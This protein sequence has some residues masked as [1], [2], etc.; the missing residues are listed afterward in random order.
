MTYKLCPLQKRSTVGICGASSFGRKVVLKIG[1]QENAVWMP[2]LCE[3][4]DSFCQ[5]GVAI[6]RSCQD[7][8]GCH[9]VWTL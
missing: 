4:S 9:V 8:D 1:E 2:G 7:G 3:L 6:R 5:N